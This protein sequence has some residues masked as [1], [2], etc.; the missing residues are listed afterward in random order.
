MSGS[1]LGVVGYLFPSMQDMAVQMAK[2]FKALNLGLT[3]RPPVAAPTATNG[4]EAMDVDAAAG[5][6]DEAVRANAVRPLAFKSLVGKGHA[7]FSSARFGT[8]FF[9]DWNSVMRGRI[10]I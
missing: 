10:K 3:G 7:E 5:K 8:G 4:D 2:V 9:W 6:D 1:D